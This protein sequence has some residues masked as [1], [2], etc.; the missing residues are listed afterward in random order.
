MLT[1]VTNNFPEFT[2]RVCPAPCESSCVLGINEMPVGI[3]SVEAAI[4]DKAWEMG[5]MVP[6]PPPQRTGKK[7]A[8]IGSGPAGLTAAD[9]LNHAGHNVT[10]Y[11]RSNKVGGILFAGI[12]NM[13]LD[14]AVVQRR[15]QLMADEGVKFVTD[16]E[17]GVHVDADTVKADHDAVI[18]AA[19][20]TMPRD[21]KI[22]GRDSAGVYM[23]M[24]FLT[25]N[26]KSLLASNHED[27]NYINAKGLDVIVIGGG[28]TG[29]FRRAMVS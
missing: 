18:I 16:T 4:I 26:T 1:S 27:G 15:V 11:E 6:Q 21:L 14:K 28:D 22:P 10:V 9:Q 24:D 12:P 2:G 25:F 19:G 20:A 23:A 17:V 5:W 3:K 8:I 13:K 29:E 7:I